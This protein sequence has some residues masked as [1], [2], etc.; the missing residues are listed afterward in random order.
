MAIGLQISQVLKEYGRVKDMVVD[1]DRDDCGAVLTEL[2]NF[3]EER[4][5]AV[6]A[7]SDFYSKT[8]VAVRIYVDASS[9]RRVKNIHRFTNMMKVKLSA[10]KE[11]AAEDESNTQ[12]QFFLDEREVSFPI[13]MVPAGV[14]DFPQPETPGQKALSTAPEKKAS[15]KGFSDIASDYLLRSGKE[16]VDK[17]TTPAKKSFPPITELRFT[18]KSNASS[19]DFD[20]VAT[21]VAVQLMASRVTNAHASA[22]DSRVGGRPQKA[23]SPKDPKESTGRSKEG[24]R[25]KIGRK[26]SVTHSPTAKGHDGR[27]MPGPEEIS[28]QYYCNEISQGIRC[29][30]VNV[31]KL[32]GDNEIVITHELNI[33]MGL[34]AEDVDLANVAS[35]V[36]RAAKAR[37]AKEE[38]EKMEKELKEEEEKT[39]REEKK[40]EEEEK[41]EKEK[42]TKLE[43]EKRQREEEKE[44]RK[45]EDKEK[46]ALQKFL[47][48]CEEA[49]RNM[50]AKREALKIK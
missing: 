12:D 39:E 21:S 3:D 41:E 8:A 16:L 9:R 37:E 43:K 11:M 5:A 40:A 20:P 2:Q 24:K 33:A 31:E 46:V 23:S 42:K 36:E 30:S 27:K 18:P 50:E 4:H 1:E 45:E 10:T 7:L 22:A 29:P 13:S 14:L 44:I 25:R 26:K 48:Q 17:F 47:D 19:K 35:K 6:D 28:T 49:K 15:S 34:L 38:V 32:R